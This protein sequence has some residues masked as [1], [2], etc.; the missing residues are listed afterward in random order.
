MS[1]MTE[2]DLRQKCKELEKY[3][4][5]TNYETWAVELWIDNDRDLLDEY[6]NRAKELFD[7][8]HKDENVKDKIWTECETTKFRLAH[9]LKDRFED[10]SP[11][12]DK[13]SVYSDLMN[14]ALSQVNWDEIAES[15]VPEVC[16]KEFEKKRK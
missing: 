8:A 13:P 7:T 14:G 5:Y 11:T 3:N 15:Y 12:A 16:K 10:E 1:E 6:T 2:W 9:A 4:G